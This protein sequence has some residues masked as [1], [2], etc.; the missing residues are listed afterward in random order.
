MH[1]VSRGFRDSLPPVPA[2]ESRD[3]YTVA[4]LTAE[5]RWVLEDSYPDLWL[6]GEI[7]NLAR[8]RSGHLYFTLKD[9]EAQIRAAMFRNHNRRLDFAAENGTKVL[10]HERVSLYRERGDFQIIVDHMERS[11]AGALRERFERL[12]RKLAEEGLFDTESKRP[13]PIFPRRVGVVTSPTGAAIHDV[14]TVLGRRFPGLPVVIY[15]TRV[16]G[17]GAAAEIAATLDLACQR[18]E[19]D[20]LLLVRGGGSIEDLWAFNEEITARAIH[21]ATLPLVAGVGHESDFTIADLVADVRAP[22]PSAAA[23][24]V[25]PDRTE[26]GQALTRARERLTARIRALNE[27]R[28]RILEATARRLRHPVATSSSSFSASTI[29]ASGYNGPGYSASRRADTVSRSSTLAW[30]GPIPASVSRS[31]PNAT[32]PCRRT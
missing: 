14:L 21:R 30:G 13:L 20:V 17:E 18:R 19:C 11:G 12:R 9:D 29:G 22:T 16:Q 31:P 15:P 27:V 26:L 7:S 5:V 3:V 24:L 6:E 23:E 2:P 8:P 4:R 28:V 32:A 25:S 1:Q 10:V